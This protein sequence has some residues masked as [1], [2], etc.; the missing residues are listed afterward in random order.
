MHLILV[1]LHSCPLKI[2]SQS[3]VQRQKCRRWRNQTTFMKFPGTRSLSC[4]LHKDILRLD[5]GKKWSGTSCILSALAK[6]NILDVCIFSTRLEMKHF[7]RNYIRKPSGVKR[8][9]AVAIGLATLLARAPIPSPLSPPPIAHFL[10]AFPP[11]PLFSFP[12]SLLPPT[13]NADGCRRNARDSLQ[14]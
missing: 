14:I 7:M 13:T 12:K 3:V 8:L 5:S 2:Q 6:S 4:A 1:Y 9:L 11:V 10:I